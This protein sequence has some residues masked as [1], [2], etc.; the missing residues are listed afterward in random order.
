MSLL[1]VGWI[2]VLVCALALVIP[3]IWR[4]RWSGPPTRKPAP[5]AMRLERPG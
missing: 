3:Q 1:L 4:R 5:R 2:A